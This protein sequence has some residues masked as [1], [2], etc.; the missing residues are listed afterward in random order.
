MFSSK[1]PMGDTMFGKEGGEGEETELLG[2][3]EV[4]S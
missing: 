3:E 4:L 2:G 1:R